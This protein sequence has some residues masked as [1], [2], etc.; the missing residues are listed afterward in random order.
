[1]SDQNIHE[2]KYNQ[3]LSKIPICHRLPDR[4]FNIRG[5]YFLVFTGFGWWFRSWNFV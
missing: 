5:H 2:S 4:T 3:I 1:M